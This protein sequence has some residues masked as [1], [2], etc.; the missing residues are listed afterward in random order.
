MQEFR[1]RAMLLGVSLY[2]H[3]TLLK[4]IGGLHERLNYK[5]FIFNPTNID[6]VSVQENHLETGRKSDNYSTGSS[7]LK[8]GK[9]K[10]EEKMNRSDIG[11]KGD[12]KL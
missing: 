9:D 12:T 4:Y 1:K 2:T 11:K 7:Q 10:G 3:D 5:F 6:E 8:E